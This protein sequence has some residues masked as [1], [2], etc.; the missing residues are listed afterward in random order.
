M[1]YAVITTIGP[2]TIGI[3]DRLADIVSTSGANIDETKAAILGGEFAVIMLV[4]GPAGIAASL[5]ARLPAAAK[6]LGLSITVKPTSGPAQPTGLPYIIESVSLD[7][8]GIVH[9]V[10]GVLHAQGVNI[11]EL[12]SNVVPAPL[13]G[14]PMF[15]M[16]I[17]INISPGARLSAL[18]EELARVAAEY[19]LDIGIRAIKTLSPGG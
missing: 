19:D 1:E 13:S 16:R 2:D 6:S 12:E 11:E 18:R 15:S 4:T 3:M 17:G 9:A 7:T 10:T 5:G 8:P 14:S